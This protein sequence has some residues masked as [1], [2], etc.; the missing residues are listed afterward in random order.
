M[1]LSFQHVIK[2]DT[3][4]SN[5][6][7]ANKGTKDPLF[8]MPIPTLMLNDNIKASAEYLEYLAKSKGYA[9][10]KAT[11][12]VEKVRQSKEVAEDVDSKETDD[13]PPVRRRPSGVVIGGEVHS[14]S[15][16]EGLDHSKKLKG[17]ET[18]S[19]AAQ[20]K[21]NMK[22]VK[23]ASRND[24]F[25]QQCPRDLG[26]GSRVTLKVHDEL[27]LEVHGVTLEVPDKPSDHSSGSSSDLEFVVEDIS[28]DE[29][30][31]TEKAEEAK[32][33][34]TE[35]NTNKHKTDEQ[36]TVKKAGEEEHGD[37]QGGNEQAGDAQA[38][39]HITKH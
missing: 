34:K 9:P 14:K 10:I 24:F 35:K 31:I 17:L 19:E 6:K 2:L 33:S 16:D 1:P 28:S 22:K 21:L 4:L 3:T 25:I 27:T 12:K 36:V 26:K 38:D 32:K 23:R 29:A 5:L 18:L 37:G 30:D 20:F 15:D 8:G 7:F 39:V 13:E 11:G